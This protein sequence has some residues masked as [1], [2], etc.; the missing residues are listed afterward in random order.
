MIYQIYMGCTMKIVILLSILPGLSSN[1][2]KALFDEI[3]FSFP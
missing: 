2:I 3:V 1:G